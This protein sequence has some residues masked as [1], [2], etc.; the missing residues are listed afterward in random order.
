M[1]GGV[2][3]G[4]QSA[5]RASRRSAGARFAV[6]GPMAIV[7]CLGALGAPAPRAAHADVDSTGS[8]QLTFAGNPLTEDAI[9]AQSGTNLSL[10]LDLI[11]GRAVYSGS[12]DPVTGSFSVGATLMCP[13]ASPPPAVTVIFS[14][15]VSA[16]GST[17]QGTFGLQDSLPP[18]F[19]CSFS[20]VS[21][22]GTRLSTTCGNGTVDAGEACDPGPPPSANLCCT[23]ACA[24]AA[25]GTICPDDGLFCTTDACDGS[26]T[27][28]HVPG[29]AGAV[30]RPQVLPCDIAEICDGV[31][32]ACPADLTNCPP[33]DIDV[34]G[35]W[36]VNY[37]YDLSGPFRRP[38]AR[39]GRREPALRRHS[40]GA[41]PGDS[42]VQRLRI[43]AEPGAPLLRR[44]RDQRDLAADG[45]T[46]TG[47]AETVFEHIL[48][49]ASCMSSV[50]TVS[51]MRIAT[52]PDCGNGVLDPGE[53]CDPGIAGSE[54]CYVDCRL[55]P[56]SAICRGVQ[57]VR[58]A[59]EVRRR[60]P[61]VSSREPD[62]P[63]LRRR[64][65]PRPV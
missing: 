19:P 39:S 2:R 46:F 43:H 29:H 24:A 30:C 41:R 35:T 33:P 5:M 12:I 57:F 47:N 60:E 4:A 56:A 51:G 21:V 8:W 63:R 49:P 28:T 23:L 65:H 25:S 62:R 38:D 11:G 32:A 14:G 36:R 48:P 50:A 22:S 1:P 45:E 59:R 61:H 10:V 13:F 20:T 58:Y 37:D 6:L 3:S 26:G 40:G 44:L 34:T 53:E 18:T 7:L 17:L 15:T 16:D 64:W 55:K 42:T 31:N 9:F 54:C 52:S 27:C